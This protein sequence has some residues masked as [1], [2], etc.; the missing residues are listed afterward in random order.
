L[1][2]CK[3]HGQAFY[4]LYLLKMTASIGLQA[5][6]DCI[7]QSHNFSFASAFAA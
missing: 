1:I 2:A 6:S 3:A 7:F 5:D 4:M